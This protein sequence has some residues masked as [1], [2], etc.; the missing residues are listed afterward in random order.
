LDGI[1]LCASSR[2]RS[3]PRPVAGASSS[4]SSMVV[5]VAVA[6]LTGSGT[7]AARTFRRSVRA[8]NDSPGRTARFV[9]AGCG[10][11]MQARG[12]SSERAGRLPIDR[13]DR[14]REDR[15]PRAFAT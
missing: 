15:Q 1:A 3:I 5:V 10:F 8:V 6:D 7:L 12:E 14:Q 2:T 4:G 13:D 9:I 11:M